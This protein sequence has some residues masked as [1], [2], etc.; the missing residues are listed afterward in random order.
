MHIINN[1]KEILLLWPLLLKLFRLKKLNHLELLYSKV[2]YSYSS[3]IINANANKASKSFSWNGML[4]CNL[5]HNFCTDTRETAFVHA[6]T[7]AGVIYAVTQGCSTGRIQNCPC[8]RTLSGKLN[9]FLRNS[10]KSRQ[11]YK[12]VY[13]VIIQ[14]HSSIFYTQN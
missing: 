7:S 3:C 8:D 9:D 11:I 14:V 10:K 5:L 1:Y 2:A 12:I 4:I 6:I 13:L